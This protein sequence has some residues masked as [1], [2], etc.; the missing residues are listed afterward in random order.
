MIV[1]TVI[2]DFQV[3]WPNY[4]LSTEMYTDQMQFGG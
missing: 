4:S 1:F 2:C 3:Y